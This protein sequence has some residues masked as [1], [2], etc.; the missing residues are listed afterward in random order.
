[1][2]RNLRGVIVGRPGLSAAM[3]GRRSELEHLLAMVPI[4]DDPSVALIAGEAGVGKTRLVRE[5]RARLPESVIILSGQATQ[6]AVGR[7]FE[8]LLEAIEPYVAS[9]DELPDELETRGRAVRAL[10]AP[11]AP[12]LGG[13]DQR[14][15]FQ[16]ELLRAAVEVVR[17]LIGENT[18]LSSCSKICTGA[19]RRASRY[20]GDSVPLPACGCSPSAPTA[21]SGSIA[22]TLWLNYWSNWSGTN[23]CSTS[24]CRG[25]P[26][27]RW[28]N[29]SPAPTE[30]RSRYGW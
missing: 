28:R 4:D 10:L 13:D 29:S 12:H 8:L 24:R 15:Y 16:Q 1:M 30:G 5:V 26:L 6:E 9:W 19:I 14:E 3:V 2:G 25:S 11:V 17:Q 21:P 23:R 18:A 27:R 7:P 20:S 22:A